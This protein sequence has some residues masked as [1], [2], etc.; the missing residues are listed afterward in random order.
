MAP[1]VIP[2]M[3]HMHCVSEN[4]VGRK[5]GCRE[6]RMPE[7]GFPRRTLLGNSVKRGVVRTVLR[8]L[9]LQAIASTDRKKRCCLSYGVHVVAY[10]QVSRVDLADAQALQ[11]V[12]PLKFGMD[13]L[14]ARDDTHRDGG[15]QLSP[16]KLLMAVFS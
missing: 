11:A 8:F 16:K 2:H 4:L 14:H 10:F 12:E 1:I 5:L 6:L 7:P 15:R 3:I 13:R 9:T